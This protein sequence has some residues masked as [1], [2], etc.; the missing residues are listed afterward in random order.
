MSGI[1]TALALLTLVVSLV[2]SSKVLQRSD[3][4]RVPMPLLQIA[5]LAM[6]AE[7]GLGGFHDCVA[8]HT[9]GLRGAPGKDAL[10]VGCVPARAHIRERVDGDVHVCAA[11]LEPPPHLGRFEVE[12]E[13][14]ILDF[15]SSANGS[16]GHGL[17][18]G[19]IANMDLIGIREDDRVLVFVVEGGVVAARYWWVDPSTPEVAEVQALVG[20]GL[21]LALSYGFITAT[22]DPTHGL[23]PAFYFPTPALMAG[24]VLVVALGI[25]AGFLPALQA[26]RLR[27]V[28]AV[29]RN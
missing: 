26:S 2:E 23:L 21:G 16:V 29:W 24:I 4:E 7:H 18:A 19:V 13:V 1:E 15:N 20:G 3:R 25:G 14:A 6:E 17:R 8:E 9:A 22:G 11:T 10:P 28:D 27:I 5:G 12:A